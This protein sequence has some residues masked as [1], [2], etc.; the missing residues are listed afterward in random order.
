[1]DVPL[2]AINTAVHVLE[3]TIA[4]DSMY[5][6][7]IFKQTLTFNIIKSTVGNSC[8]TPW[9]GTVAHSDMPLALP[10]YSCTSTLVDTSKLCSA[11]LN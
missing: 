8:K 11:V 9:C 7:F 2:P 4:T 3:R 6:T 5:S 1:M 10:L